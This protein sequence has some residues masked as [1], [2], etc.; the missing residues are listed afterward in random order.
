MTKNRAKDIL[1]PKNE[2]AIN[3][4]K[5]LLR[6]ARFA[7]L[8]SLTPETGHPIASRVSLANEIDGTPLILVSDLS[9]HTPALKADARS[10]LLIGEP[11]KG[12]PLAHARMTI[13][14]FSEFLDRSSEDY[15]YARTRFL[16]RHPKAALYVDFGDFHFFR[17]KVATISLNAGFGKAYKLEKEDLIIY[18]HLPLAEFKKTE[19]SVLEHMNEDHQQAIQHY[20]E[21]FCKKQEKGWQLSGLDPEGLDLMKGDEI[22]RLWFDKPLES[23]DEI[24]QKLISLARR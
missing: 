2:E 4:A 14:C 3:R 7:A 5:T 16:N 13:T 11:A 9:S 22:T 12:D 21:C 23:V 19:E 1:Q 17:L 6:E 18:E 10:S 20:A 8:A 24:R 15:I